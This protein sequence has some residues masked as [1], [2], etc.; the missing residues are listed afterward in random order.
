MDKKS[1]ADL[2]NT[3]SVIALYKS[4]LPFSLR[5]W[6]NALGL[7]VQERKAGQR[8]RL[9]AGGSLRSYL[10]VCREGEG[11]YQVRKFDNE[12]W[13][14]RFAHLVDATYNIADYLRHY[15][16]QTCRLDSEKSAILNEA[17]EHF[18]S[19]QE[20]LW[21]PGVAV[22]LEGVSEQMALLG[23]AKLN[24]VISY[25]ERLRYG[26][27]DPLDWQ[28]LA[29]LY[30]LAA[31]YKDME[32]AI[33]TAYDLV[34]SDFGGLQWI[35]WRWRQTVGM[36]YFAAFSNSTRL[37]EVIVL[38]STP[39]KVTAESLGYSANKARTLA[40]KNLSRTLADAKRAG[41]KGLQSESSELRRIELAL[42]ACEKR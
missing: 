20:W 32:E 7:H 12:T 25:A 24:E 41:D 18:K 13:E 40:E 35:A 23:P 1:L 39:S 37:Q 9:Q 17:I 21:L 2:L 29:M 38:G 4:M 11:D 42:A 3:L 26:S 30:D 14:R 5:G 28:F 33:K 16:A 22:D 10:D 34:R 27:K 19:T 31:R 6:V 36:L 15:T 8:A